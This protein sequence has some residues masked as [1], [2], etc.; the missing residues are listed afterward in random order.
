MKVYVSRTGG[1]ESFFFIRL[2]G[3]CVGC[4]MR[5]RGLSLLPKIMLNTLFFQVKVSSIDIK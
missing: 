5:S 3:R 1:D 4:V 2:Q